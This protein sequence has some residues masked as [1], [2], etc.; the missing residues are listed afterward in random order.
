MTEI[1]E[2]VGSASHSVGDTPTPAPLAVV[3]K[4]EGGDSR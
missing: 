2:Q 1:P 3:H 4:H